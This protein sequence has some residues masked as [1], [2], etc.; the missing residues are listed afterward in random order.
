MF[1]RTFCNNYLRFMNKVLACCLLIPFLICM[2]AK[3]QEL[4]VKGQVITKSGQPVAGAMVVNRRTYTGQF[5]NSTGEFKIKI[6]QTDTLSVGAFGMRSQ[7]ITFSDSLPK[8]E[9]SI[10][11]V[12]DG[13][14][15][16]VGTAEVFA[17]R[18]LKEIYKDIDGLGF[19]ESDYRLSGIDALSSPITFLYERFSKREQSRRLALELQNADRRRELL[20]ELF[21]KYVDYDIIQLDDDQFDEFISF[22]NVDDDFLKSSSQYN[23]LLYVKDRFSAYKKI[24]RELKESDYYYHQ[25]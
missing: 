17:P 7:S 8:N 23:F 25:D 4:V 9:Y 6:L 22:L 24:K 12:L 2:D 18:D 1:E 14:Q 5:G 11:V 3:G 21:Q 20:K 15:V 13:L 16:E 19:E 10:T